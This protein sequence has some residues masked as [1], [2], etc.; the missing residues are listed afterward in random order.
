MGLIQ[1]THALLCHHYM[2]QTLIIVILWGSFTDEL[3]AASE[4]LATN[5]MSV[6][7][8]GVESV[9]TDVTVFDLLHSND[10]CAIT[11]T[12]TKV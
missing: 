8:P 12:Q 6:K 10:S 7:T 9:A 2:C 11:F 4:G 3:T 1:H 5:A